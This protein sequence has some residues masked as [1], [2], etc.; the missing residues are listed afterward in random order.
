[1]RRREFI[2]ELGS[3][4]AAWPFLARAQHD[5]HRIKARHAFDC[6]DVSRIDGQH[7][8]QRGDASGVVP[9]SALPEYARAIRRNVTYRGPSPHI[10]TGPVFTRAPC[11]VMCWKYAF[12]RPI[13]PLI[14]ATPSSALYRRSARRV[15]RLFSAHHSHRSPSK[16]GHIGAGC[17][18]AGEPTILWC[19]G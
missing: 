19:D 2:A 8:I 16:D 7:R 11:R 18:G 10:L 9:P 17:R 13:W 1:M 3:V 12:D 15:H 6:D 14:T 5:D 4:L